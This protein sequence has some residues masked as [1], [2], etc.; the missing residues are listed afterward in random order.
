MEGQNAPDPLARIV[1]QEAWRS[2]LEDR[3]KPDPALLADGW[4]RR[5][6]ADGRQT[7]EAVDLY[8]SLGFEVR[9]VPVR[10][11]ELN[12][13]CAGCRLIAALQFQTL[14]TRRR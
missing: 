11:D 7:R 10:P 4:Q 3:I 13:E 2:A 1:G 6:V 8:A 9:S 12:D 5:F 14:Y